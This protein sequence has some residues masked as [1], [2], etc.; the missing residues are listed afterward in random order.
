M[1]KKT[2]KPP[3]PHKPPETEPPPVK[4]KRGKQSDPATPP[5]EVAPRAIPKPKAL[6]APPSWTGKLPGALLNEHCQKLGWNKVDYA[7]V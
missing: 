7:M 1:A 3:K 4:L 6:V 2:P 5:N